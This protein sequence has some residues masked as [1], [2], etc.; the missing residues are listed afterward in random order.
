MHATPGAPNDPAQPE[1]HVLI[2]EWMAD[3]T[4]TLADP[5]DGQFEDWFELYNAGTNTIDLGG[6]WLTD[7]LTNA[8]QFR[9]PTGYVM[10][11]GGFL[12]VWADG[13][14][15]QN[16][17]TN[18]DLHAG[19]KLAADG[20][21][22]GL[23]SATGTLIDAVVFGTQTNDVARGRFPSGG[24]E[25]R[26]LDRPTPGVGNGGIA[27]PAPH[28]TAVAQVADGVVSLT[29]ESTPGRRYQVEFKSILDEPAWT[30]LSAPVTAVDETVTIV[31]TIMPRT[32]RFYRVVRI[33]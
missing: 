4:S 7:N 24:N 33:E 1:I 25:I 32:L 19:F 13:E 6:C 22:I 26:F 11:P 18:A 9:V 8:F 16:S 12:L 5:A 2:N 10:P 29:W 3:N 15:G 27:F 17:P 14:P 20:E 28:I 30:R 21:A 31:D 23:F